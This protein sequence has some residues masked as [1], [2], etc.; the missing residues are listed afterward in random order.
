MTDEFI[1]TITYKQE[2]TDFKARLLLQGYVHKF[3][4]MVDEMEIFFEPDEEGHYR[5]VKMSWQDEKQIEKID[6][7]LLSVIAQKIEAVLA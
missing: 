6:K 3:R 7:N 4:V 5:A 1:L 2:Q